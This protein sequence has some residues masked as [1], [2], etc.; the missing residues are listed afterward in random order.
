MNIKPVDTDL[1]RLLWD[2]CE[3]PLQDIS[4][5]LG[6]SHDTIYKYAKVLQLPRRPRAVRR[7]DDDPTPE[8]IEERA[9]VIRAKWTDAERERRQVGGKA[10]QWA[11][12]RF[13]YSGRELLFSH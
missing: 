10:Q 1:L 3:V 11:P 7:S 2:D 8:Q 5:R 6:V 4:E 9:A 13:V 12:P